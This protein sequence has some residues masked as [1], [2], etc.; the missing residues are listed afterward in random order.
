MSHLYWDVIH[1]LQD[2]HG[3]GCSMPG[4]HITEGMRSYGAW[5][6]QMRKK[7]GKLWGMDDPNDKENEELL[8]LLSHEKWNNGPANLL[9]IMKLV[10]FGGDEKK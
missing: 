8:A 2:T 9:V 4:E 10:K 1:E 3:L 7:N 5:M 6:I